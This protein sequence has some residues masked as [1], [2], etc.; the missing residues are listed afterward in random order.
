MVVSVAVSLIMMD[1]SVP[2]SVVVYVV[3]ME[4]LAL[5]VTVWMGLCLCL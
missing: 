3:V 1:G 5:S 2:M 4:P